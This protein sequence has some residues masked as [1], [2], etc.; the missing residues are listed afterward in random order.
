MLKLALFI[1]H[2]PPTMREEL[3]LPEDIR[4]TVERLASV[5]IALVTTKDELLYSIEG[6]E[7]VML[8]SVYQANIGN[9]RRSWVAGRRAMGI[10]QL[11]GLHRTDGRTQFHVIDKKAIYNT[12][13]IWLRIMFLDRQICLL[14]GLPEG[15]PDRTMDAGPDFDSED[16]IGQ[17]ESIYCV[18]SSRILE[19]NALKPSADNYPLTRDLDIELQKA[20]RRLPSKWWLPP[21]LQDLESSETVFWE[22]RRIFTQV[23]HYNLLNQLHLPYMLR[24]SGGSRKN[25]YEYSRMTC[26]NASREVLVRFVN[27]RTFNGIS[28]VCRTLDFIALMS[29]MTLILAHLASKSSETE[30]L[31]AHQYLSDRA[32]IEKTQENMVAMN[33][34]NSDALSAKSANLLGRLLALEASVEGSSQRA[35]KIQVHE[36]ENE[37]D[38]SDENAQDVVIL[39][40]PYFGTVRIASEGLRKEAPSVP[41]SGVGRANGT[42]NT[43]MYGQDELIQPRSSSAFAL[44]SY[45]AMV[46]TEMPQY[47][48]ADPL[49]HDELP[50]LTAQGQD[51]ALQGTDL[52]FFDSLMGTVE[53]GESEVAYWR[54]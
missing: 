18:I 19:R 40:I 28:Y 45:H 21:T 8:E 5:A 48:F 27:L 52:A 46:D 1:H 44:D 41:E 42:E 25:E 7:C 49:Q 51:W 3:E 43:S 24:S 9:L 37:T 31:L 29:A 30:N 14:L 26:V 20:A 50:E 13:I 35:R 54:L 34:V 39:N 16:E 47:D 22:S 32:M 11:M 17:M 53:S 23:V 38:L 10:A 6:L 4:T 15:S 12:R 33:R 2:F 36:A